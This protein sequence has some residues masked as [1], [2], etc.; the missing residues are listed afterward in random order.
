M[1]A[2]TRK[3]FNDCRSLIWWLIR[4]LI[5]RIELRAQGKVH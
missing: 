3:P 4:K 5:G 2:G 1:K